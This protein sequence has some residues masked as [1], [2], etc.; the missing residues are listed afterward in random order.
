[1]KL[2]IDKSKCVGHARCAAVAPEIFQLDDAGYIAQEEIIARP[3]AKTSRAAARAPA[4]SASSPSSRSPDRV[5][6]VISPKVIRI[7]PCRTN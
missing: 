3:A 4:P 2:L 7:E 5:P 1:M 6:L